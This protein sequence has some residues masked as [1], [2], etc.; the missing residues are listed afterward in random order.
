M[1][2]T[3]TGEIGDCYEYRVNGRR[4][5]G[6]DRLTIDAMIVLSG[7]APYDG[8]YHQYVGT[9]GYVT[10]AHRGRELTPSMLPAR[11]RD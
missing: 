3:R 1:T 9:N 4:L 6:T 10:W 11:L 7:R 5:A 2:H 8:T